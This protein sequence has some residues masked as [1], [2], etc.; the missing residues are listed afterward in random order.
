ME[1]AIVRH[2]LVDH[3]L[4]GIDGSRLR[5]LEKAGVDSLEAVVDIGPERLAD[6]TGFDLKTSQALIRVAQSALARSLPGV[7]EFVPPNAEP[8]TARLA[9]GLEAARELERWLGLARAARSQVGKEPPK[10][11]W[12]EA[13]SKARRQLKKLTRTLEE[14][15]QDVLADGLSA[16]GFRHLRTQLAS[17]KGLRA[18]LDAPAGRKVYLR[19][20]KGA[21]KVRRAVRQRRRMR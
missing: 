18:E 15:Q 21:K 10:A 9:R 14:L 8:P 11:K 7:I 2:A 17:L 5:K 1:W 19:I 16:R 20:S 6:L 4:P 12:G 13:H 3:P